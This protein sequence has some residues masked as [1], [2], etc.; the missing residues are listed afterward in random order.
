MKRLSIKSYIQPFLSILA[1]IF[2]SLIPHPWGA[3]PLVGIAAGYQT[4]NSLIKLCA[5]LPALVHDLYNGFHAT[6]LWVYVS[7]ILI[8]YISPMLKFTSIKALTASALFFGVSN[9]G[10]WYSTTLYPLSFAGLVACYLAAIPFYSNLLV[11][12]FI[13]T[14]GFTYL[15]KT[16]GCLTIKKA[17]CTLTQRP[18]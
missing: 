10:V 15:T 18:S 16:K 2:W 3:T 14:F 11:S 1:P 17:F 6:S 9:F 5:F 13:F 8:A 7:L 12:T 4:Q